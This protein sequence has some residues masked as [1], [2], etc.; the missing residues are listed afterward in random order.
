[1]DDP[2]NLPLRSAGSEM[3]GLLLLVPAIGVVFYLLD[4][5]STKAGLILTDMVP[6]GTPLPLIT[7]ITMDFP[8]LVAGGVLALLV[9]IC[10]FTLRKMFWVQR[11]LVLL[12]SAVWFGLGGFGLVIVAVFSV[13]L[14][15][16]TTGIL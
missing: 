16:I 1:M 15:Q 13:P 10:A 7:R 5:L 8:F 6:E 2:R 12:V 4:L 14:M 11:H 9:L 3:F